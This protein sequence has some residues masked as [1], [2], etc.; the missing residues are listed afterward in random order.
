MFLA[1]VSESKLVV[2]VHLLRSEE[3][4]SVSKGSLHKNED[5]K[6]KSFNDA[7]TT[8]QE[9]FNSSNHSLHE[10]KIHSKKLKIFM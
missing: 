7:G 6:G 9:R 2:C 1:T 10:H 5:M 3:M 8:K 4:F